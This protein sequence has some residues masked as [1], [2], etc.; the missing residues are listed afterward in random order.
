MRILHLTDCYMPR[1]GGIERQVHDLAVRQADAGHDVEIV[2]I[3][4]GDGGRDDIVT[5]RPAAR[6]GKPGTIQYANW[7][8]GYRTVRAGGYDVIHLHSST[9]SPMAGMALRTAATAGI[10]TVVTVHSLWNRYWPLFSIANHLFDWNDYPIVWTA[11]STVAAGPVARHLRFGGRARR[12]SAVSALP[13]AVDHSAWQI[14]PLRRRPDRVVIAS[15]MRLAHRK[16]PLQYLEMLRRARDLVPSS[17][18]L[19]AII[20]GDGPRRAG[21]EHYLAKHDMTGWVTLYGRGTH[22]QIREVY[23]DSDFFVAPATLESFGIAALE[24]RSAG[25]PV[26]AHAKSGVRDFVTHGREGL[27]AEGDADMARRIAQLATSPKLRAQ[28]TR[29][30][31]DNTPQFGWTEVLERCQ[32]LYATAGY[33]STDPQP[34]APHPSAPLPSELPVI[35]PPTVDELAERT[36]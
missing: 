12:R 5:H 34:G 22:E 8:L 16:R 27:L 2:T 20:V 26:I 15:V 3:V 32:Q 11:V 13:N 10:P 9:W 6:R 1:M 21:M 33:E 14:E 30:N 18:A 19:E 17:I 36:A 7:R 31:R 35:D 24:A 23:R 4:A 25:L 29:F 28:M